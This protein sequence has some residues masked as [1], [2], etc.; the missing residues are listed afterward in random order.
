LL[1]GVG[2]LEEPIEDGG[3]ELL[4]GL[5]V[6]LEVAATVCNLVCSLRL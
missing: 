1:D 3:G 6:P 5:Q 4:K 2:G